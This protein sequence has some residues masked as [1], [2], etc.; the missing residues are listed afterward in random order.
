LEWCDGNGFVLQHRQII[1]SV[2]TK[3]RTCGHSLKLAEINRNRAIFKVSNASDQYEIF[4]T[5]AGKV[6]SFS[7]SDNK[8]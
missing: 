3:F 6:Y 4:S 5:Q 7:K 1:W 2:I 8:V